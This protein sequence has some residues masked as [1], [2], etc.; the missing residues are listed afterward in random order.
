VRVHR[1]RR[2]RP[3]PRAGA[4]G[5]RS[6]EEFQR[7]LERLTSNADDDVKDEFDLDDFDPPPEVKGGGVLLRVVTFTLALWCHALAPLGGRWGAADFAVARTSATTA[8]LFA[9]PLQWFG[10]AF[11]VSALASGAFARATRAARLFQPIRSDGP[12]SHATSKTKTKT[13]TAGG[14]VFIPLGC[15]V[16]AVFTRCADPSAN[17]AMCCT[18]LF[19]LIG[20]RDDLGKLRGKKNDAGLAPFEKFAAQ[21]LVAGSYVAAIAAL[22]RSN[23]AGA[24]DTTVTFGFGVFGALWEQIL[25]G[26]VSGLSGI[27]S[28]FLPMGKWFY[29]LSAFA[30]VSESN[31]V[32]VTDGVDGLAASL[33]AVAFV[34]LGVVCVAGG[35]P[36]L[37][38]FAVS[39]GGASCGFLAVNRHPA[40]LFMGD[41]GSLALGGALGAIAAAAG[42]RATFPLFCITLVFVAE[43]LSVFAQVGWFKWTKR[44]TGAGARLFRMA[45]L[46]HHLELGGWG[47]VRVVA[48]LC[49][50][51]AVCAL[52][53]VAVAGG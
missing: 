47:E 38:A 41:S 45:P 46:H 13:P 50:I 5:P 35:K 51:G 20:A 18:L 14:V 21:C 40:S 12:A 1:S 31:A 29:V 36:E 9:T 22:S 15:L 26:H 8:A 17:A 30:I 16:A 32:N 24:V 34:A 10:V 42:G 43:V 48:T 27:K 19:L 49:A 4:D 23:V 33:C 25:T 52:V 3:S 53:G 7:D 39:M 11:V 28:L 2:R 6:F 44:K 37:G